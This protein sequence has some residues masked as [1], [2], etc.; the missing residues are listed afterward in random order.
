[1]GQEVSCCQLTAHGDRLCLLGICLG[2]CQSLDVVSGWQR[3]HAVY[4]RMQGGPAGLSIL[5]QGTRRHLVLARSGYHSDFRET[6][7]QLCLGRWLRPSS[8]SGSFP[9]SSQT[10]SGQGLLFS[11]QHSFG[12]VGTA[13]Y[14]KLSHPMAGTGGP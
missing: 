5:L 2:C 12:C 7:G 8:W 4:W 1:M 13:T 6:K 3:G 10:S 9:T 14:F 11:L